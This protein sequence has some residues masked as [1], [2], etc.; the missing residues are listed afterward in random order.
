MQIDG[1]SENANKTVLAV[2]E[3][4][5][6]KGVGGV[7]EIIVSRLP[8]GHTHEDIDSKFAKLWE[9]FR[10]NFVLSPEGYRRAIYETFNSDVLDVDVED[11]FA[12]PDYKALFEECIDPNI[13]G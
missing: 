2:L 6:F 7:T 13:A 8:V 12:V 1:G 10:N 4:L 9:R 11:I 5:I 3:Y